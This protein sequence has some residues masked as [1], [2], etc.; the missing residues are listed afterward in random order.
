MD[1]LLGSVTDV[2]YFRNGCSGGFVGPV[3]L[4]ATTEPGKVAPACAD[5]RLV[6]RL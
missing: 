2:E 6:V 5:T 3:V 1:L 4:L